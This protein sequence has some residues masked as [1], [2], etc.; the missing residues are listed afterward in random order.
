MKCLSVSNNFEMMLPSEAVNDQLKSIISP[1]FTKIT[2]CY[3]TIEKLT[4]ARD[5]LLPKLMSGE[6]E[7]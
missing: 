3:F 6:I 2:D 5:R 1:L 7:V 4:E